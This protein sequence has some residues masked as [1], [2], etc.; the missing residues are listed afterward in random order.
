ME[1]INLGNGYEI[2]YI[3]DAYNNDLAELVINGMPQCV[4]F[5]DNRKYLF[6]DKYSYL[7]DTPCNISNIKSTLVLGG[8]SFTYPKYYIAKYSDK[9]MDVVELNADLIKAAHT[10]FYLNDLY[11]DFDKERQRLKIYNDDCI[12]FINNI[13]KKYDYIFFDAYIGYNIVPAIYDENTILKL[14]SLLN[15]NGYLAINYVAQDPNAYLQIQRVLRHHFKCI[16][17]Y[18]IQEDLKFRYILVSDVEI[19]SEEV[20]SR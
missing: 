8:G 4:C 15:E 20:I 16:K 13:D 7:Y 11:N 5:T 14:K 19:K 18:A 3:K 12:H 2:K 10:Y 9:T 1:N 6:Y 17:E